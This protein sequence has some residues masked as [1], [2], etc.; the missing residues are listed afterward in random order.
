MP[1]SLAMLLVA[2][3]DRFVISH[4]LGLSAVGV[5]AL[6]YRI[7]SVLET[8]NGSLGNAYRAMFMAAA[9]ALPEAPTR[10]AP[11]DSLRA[12]ALAR[13]TRSELWLLA[14]ASLSGQGLA[15][16][17]RELLLV[18]GIDAVDFADAWRV[19]YIVC[20]GLFAHAAYV[21]LATPL[22]HAQ[23]G[24]RRLP[25]ISAAAAL[26]NVLAC[27]V[28]VPTSGILAAAWATAASHITLAC[29]AWLLARELSPAPRAWRGCALLL[30]CHSLSLLAG[31]HIERQLI[32]TLPRLAA[33]ASLLL[34]GCLCTLGA[35]HFGMRTSPRTARAPHP[36][37]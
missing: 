31:W 10:A 36:P 7:A 3:A 27:V 24:T 25:W 22:F 13:I 5:Y 18:A 14:A 29:G 1:H 15:L 9:N 20:W 8:V 34:A 6:G 30:T 28:Y 11:H 37:A 4:A 35:V 17:S 33:K 12:D 2:M 21:L 23:L 16:A 32:D 26:V 19:T